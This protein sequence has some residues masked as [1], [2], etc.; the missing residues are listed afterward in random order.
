M[1][2][3]AAT[4]CACSDTLGQVYTANIIVRERALDQGVHFIQKPVSIG[5][6]PPGPA[7]RWIQNRR[8]KKPSGNG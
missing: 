3:E 6:Q 5:G 2:P 8:D 4:F 7:Q 1:L